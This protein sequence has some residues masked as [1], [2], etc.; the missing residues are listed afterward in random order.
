MPE[1]VDP[2]PATPARGRFPTWLKTTLG[3]IVVGASFYFLVS[4]LVQDWNRIPFD[5]LRFRPVPLVLSYV[6]FLGLHYP[7]IAWGWK[8]ILR[9]LGERISTPRGLAIITV[10]QLGKYIPGK[11]WFALGRIGMAAREGIPKTKGLVS[12]LIET[13]FSLLAAVLLFAV[14]VL[15]LPRG[16]VP[17]PVYWL[18]ALAPLCLVVV[19][20]PVL[21][22]VLAFLLR[23]LKRPVFEL[24]LSYPR[25]LLI[26]LV[27]CLDWFF[28]GLG[29][30]ALLSSFYP[31]GLEALPVIV[32]GYAVAWIL[33]FL[34]VV[35]PAGLGVRE[36]I[37]TVVART[38]MPAPM[39][40]AASFLTRVWTTIGEV[41]MALAFAAV[42]GKRRKHGTP[43]E[44]VASPD[45]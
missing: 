25:L 6:C 9:G 34:A 5:T 11:V 3:I 23:R 27:Y 16:S 26:L 42:L 15:F 44:T 8:L 2:R 30:Y 35:A 17:A 19:Y 14:T 13:G 4:R 29:N 10:T 12:I 38:V 36:G 43:E 37:Y 31:L 39:A 21:N 24:R 22:R 28:H 20:P 7:L 45:R 1:P 18:F 32:G 41:V 40:I 33:G